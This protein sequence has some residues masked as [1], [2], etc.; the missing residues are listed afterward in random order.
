MAVREKEVEAIQAQAKALAQEDQGA[1][2]VERTSRA[3]EEK[4]RALCQPMRERCQR[5]QASREQHQFHR[6]VED[7]IVSHEG[8][9]SRSVIPTA[10]CPL[11]CAGEMLAVFPSPLALKAN[12]LGTLGDT[13]E[14]P[15]PQNQ[16]WSPPAH[17]PGA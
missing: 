10:N 11:P 14:V 1:G 16:R 15:F 7:E 13:L 2:E 12:P 4:F 3:V 8:R 17:T 9:G 5:L 6:D